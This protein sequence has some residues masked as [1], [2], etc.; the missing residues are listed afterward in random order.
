MKKGRGRA[1]SKSA[2]EDRHQECRLALS[3]YRVVLQSVDWRHVKEAALQDSHQECRLMLSHYKTNIKSVDWRCHVKEAVL[4]DRQWEYG[5]A[6][7]TWKKSYNE[8]KFAW[9][10]VQALSPLIIFLWPTTKDLGLLNVWEKSR[11]FLL[12]GHWIECFINR[13]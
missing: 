7:G 13:A 5:M 9:L 6:V 12:L 3:R 2:T 10:Y 8:F 4:P 1:P 11:Q